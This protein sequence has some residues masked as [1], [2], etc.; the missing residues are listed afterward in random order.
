MDEIEG[1]DED[2]AESE[3][4]GEEHEKKE[5]E[6]E[7]YSVLVVGPK[8]VMAGKRRDPKNKY[9]TCHPRNALDSELRMTMATTGSM[10][11]F[12]ISQLRSGP[13]TKGFSHLNRFPS[14]SPIMNPQ[15][16][17]PKF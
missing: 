12:T 15:Y 16:F 11:C 6:E 13:R 4:E 9:C 5:M 1:E 14:T 3:N 8:G 10:Q 2:R 7:W 17:H